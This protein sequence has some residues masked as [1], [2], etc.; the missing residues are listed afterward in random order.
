[1]FLKLQGKIFEKIRIGENFRKSMQNRAWGWEKAR[2]SEKSDKKR[3]R[4][5]YET[6]NL[7]QT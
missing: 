6:G 7:L 2:K 3:G 1:M 5:N 4:K